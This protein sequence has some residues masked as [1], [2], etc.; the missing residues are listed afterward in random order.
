MSFT[1]LRKLNAERLDLDIGFTVAE[2]KENPVNREGE[3][4][5]GCEIFDCGVN[6][7]RTG[8]SIGLIGASGNGKTSWILHNFK[9][10]LLNKKTGYCVMIALEMTD[11][12]LAKK[13][14]K[15]IGK[16]KELQDRL[17]IISAYNGD[18]PRDLSIQGID[19]YLGRIRSVREGKMWA[20]A[21]DHLHIVQKKEP[22]VDNDSIVERFMRLSQIHEALGILTS[23]TTKSKGGAGDVPLEMT[24]CY[25]CSRFEWYMTQIYTLCQ[26]LKRIQEQVFFPVTSWKIAKNRF[27]DPKNDPIALGS[28]QLA[29]FD[30]NTESYRPMT[31]DE[32]FKFTNLVTEAST[33]RKNDVGGDDYV[34][35]YK[36]EITNRKGQKE[37]LNKVVSSLKDVDED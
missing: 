26:P 31:N 16:N 36:Q 37:V 34:F 24:A 19:N 28:N 18:N 22:Y 7:W 2:I 1:K 14:I 15:V 30:V 35:N 20:F 12:E 5:E 10:I 29:Y 27:S 6:K 9:K 8:H 33:L 4:V 11:A 13:W 17:T 32:Y 23:Q 25:N 3:L 21:V